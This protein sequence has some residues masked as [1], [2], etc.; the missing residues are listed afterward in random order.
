MGRGVRDVQAPVKIVF[1]PRAWEQY[2]SWAADDAKILA[3][4][5]ALVQDARRSPFRGIGKPEPL[6]D[7]LAG[8]WSRRI[9]EQHRLVYR[10][11]GK[12]E[13]RVLEILQCRFHYDR[14]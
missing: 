2:L 6:R 12:G 9:T 5:N 1:L 10:V 13:D 3:R 4:L 7:S 8:W 11:V 14:R